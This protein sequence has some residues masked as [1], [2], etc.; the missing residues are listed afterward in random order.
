MRKRTEE[1]IWLARALRRVAP[2]PMRKAVEFRILLIAE[3]VCISRRAKEPAT[4]QCRTPAV[5][6]RAAHARATV[7]RN[8]TYRA[9]T[10]FALLAVP[11]CKNPRLSSGQLNL[12]EPM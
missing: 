5:Y 9:K 11:Q 4:P 7:A 6:S 12:P 1:M 8:R 2:P 10:P 3:F